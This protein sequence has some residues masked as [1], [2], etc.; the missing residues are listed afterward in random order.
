M[1]SGISSNTRFF[2]SDTAIFSIILDWYTSANDLQSDLTIF[3]LNL[4]R[5]RRKSF[6][7]AKLR[8]KPVLFFNENQVV[9]TCRERLGIHLHSKLSFDQYLNYIA[10]KVDEK[11]MRLLRKFQTFLRKKSLSTIY[12]FLIRSD[13]NYG[14]AIS[15]QAFDKSFHER[16]KTIHCPSRHLHDQS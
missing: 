11:A 8:A 2:V 15:D 6:S 3:N 4:L 16:L 10:R 9:Q 14:Y 13:Q 5:K 12:K 1:W 7:L